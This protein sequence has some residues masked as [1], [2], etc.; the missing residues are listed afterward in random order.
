V[1]P[2]AF[3][4]HETLPDAS[5]RGITASAEGR[6]PA[7]GALPMKWVAVALL[8]ALLAACVPMKELG[9]GLER[10][11]IVEVA[12]EFCAAQASA[13]PDDTWP[14]LAKSVRDSLDNLA[15]AE[16]EPGFLTSA[17]PADGCQPGR[18]WYRGGSRLFAEIR[19]QVGSD[20]LGF[21]KSEWPRIGDIQYGRPRAMGG[22]RVR[23]LREGLIVL[24]RSAPPPPLPP[25]TECFPPGY[26]FAF[27]A[28]DT[29]IHRQGAR[30]KLAP[31]VNLAPAG[32][33]PLPARCASDWSVTGPAELSPDRGLL[34]LAP[35]APVGSIVTVGFKHGGKP[36]EAHLRVIGREEIVLT[37]RRSQQ[38]VE[39]CEYAEP[40]REL[41]F[42][43]GNR[44]SVTFQ[45]FETYRDYWGSYTFD[46]A[47]GAIS[48]KV[49]GG[50]FVPYG[51]D[52]EGRAEFAQGRLTLA[53]VFFGSRQGP[54]QKDCTY[55]F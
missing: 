43:P 29:Q 34:T 52:L 36:V 2:D 18:I 42:S 38:G 20:R 39:G 55:R 26:H 8:P 4:V 25:D 6:S 28:M 13:D 11:R 33:R 41:E 7:E 14:L 17:D 5:R 30:I 50:N 44:F 54:P 53:N 40:V 35:D 9:E 31:E 10:A 16:M 27:L 46:P 48:F 23:S 15:A 1:R 49:E 45:P 51:L 22:V 19:L 47:S 37:G 32:T 21:W 24:E 12:T 3:A